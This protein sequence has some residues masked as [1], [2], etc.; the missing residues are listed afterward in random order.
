[1][2]IA[3]AL[4]TQLANHGYDVQA[5]GFGYDG[6]E[7][8]Y[9]FRIAPVVDIRY[10]IPMVRSLQAQGVEIEALIVALDIPLQE[11]ILQQLNAPCDIPYIGL[12]PIE[13]PPLC[14]SW[15]MNLLR[16]DARLIMSH[17]GVEAAKAMGIE[18]TYIPIG[19]DCEVW[20]PAYPEERAQLRKGLGIGENTFAVLTVA[21]NQERK[22]LSRSMEIFADAFKGKDARYLMVTRPNSPVGWKLQ[23][24]ATELDIF[25]QMAIWDRGMP[26]KNLW[27]LFAASDCFL[28]TSKAEGLAMPV[29]EAMAMRLPVV[30]TN[31]TAIAEHLQ[32]ERGWLIKPDYAI[33]DAFGN[34]FRYF[35][36]REGGKVS[37]EFSKDVI[38]SRDAEL[39]NMLDRAQ[40]YVQALTWNKAG[41]VLVETIEK[42]K[43]A[44]I[45]GIELPVI[46][47]AL[48]EVS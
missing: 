45:P 19:V 5:L 42:A 35:A 36:S 24:Y 46:L 4:C 2:N 22:N 15:A 11:G 21:D 18:A 13:A 38:E 1:M 47:E 28:L 39:S 29:L 48:A 20:R 12:F 23:D 6:G 34:G 33:T 17:F 16:M 37:L 43:R 25:G 14:A 31:C 32:G 30:G 27:S 8:N 41:T 7:H 3:V 10:A 9:P 44:R 40:A 26:F